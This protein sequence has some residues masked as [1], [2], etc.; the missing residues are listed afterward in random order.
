ME[1]A[2]AHFRIAT[3]TMHRSQINLLR[4]H[5][6]PKQ[7]S[8]RMPIRHL[9]AARYH[10]LAATARITGRATPGLDRWSEIDKPATLPAATRGCESGSYLRAHRPHLRVLVWCSIIAT[11]TK[12]RHLRTSHQALIQIDRFKR[13]LVPAQLPTIVV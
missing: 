9:P 4:I 5:P 7:R 10:W 3:R 13:K 2:R 1:L 8:E 11:W 6:V 12:A